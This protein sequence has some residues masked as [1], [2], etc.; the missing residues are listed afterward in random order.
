[1]KKYIADI[2]FNIYNKHYFLNDKKKYN[3]HL[4]VNYLISFKF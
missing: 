4:I 2:F 1:M 3:E